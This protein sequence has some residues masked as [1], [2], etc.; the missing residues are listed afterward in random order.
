MLLSDG[1]VGMTCDISA[2]GLSLALPADH[3]LGEHLWFELR[4]S[5]A[6][7]R[8]ES[9]GRVVRRERRNG[10]LRVAIELLRA[11]LIPND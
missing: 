8:F 9:E 11:R 7:L 3:V 6:R 1:A 5:T 2:S 10:E 4:L